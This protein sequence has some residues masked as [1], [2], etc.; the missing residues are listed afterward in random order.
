MQLVIDL[1][2]AIPPL[3]NFVLFM[4][5]T[6]KNQPLSAAFF[7]DQSFS[8]LKF[9]FVLASLF[10]ILVFHF[11]SIEFPVTP[12]PISLRAQSFSVALLVSLVASI[13]LPPSL[14]WVA[15]L[16]IIV[17]VPWHNQLFL[18]IVRLFRY[19]ARTLQS[20]PTIFIYITQNYE[21]PDPFPPHDVELQLE[22]DAIETES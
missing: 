20:I 10:L 1:R 21:R 11:F 7:M 13:S 19:F 22:T 12:H 3:W 14:F 8:I 17:T 5:L 2:Y 16:F 9:A 18:Q 15:F 4:F 6:S